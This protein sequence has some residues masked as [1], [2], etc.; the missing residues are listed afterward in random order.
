MAARPGSARQTPIGRNDRQ[1]NPTSRK[2]SYLTHPSRGRAAERRTASASGLRGNSPSR[3]HSTKPGPVISTR[4]RLGTG[5]DAPRSRRAGRGK[6][7][8]HPTSCRASGSSTR[9]PGSGGARALR[10]PSSQTQLAR[11]R[12]PAWRCLL[13]KPPSSAAGPR[14]SSRNSTGREMRELSTRLAWRPAPSRY[15]P[16]PPSPPPSPPLAPS[17]C[18]PPFP[19]R[20]FAAG[21]VG[22]VAGRVG[23][24]DGRP[25]TSKPT[26]VPAARMRAAR[27]ALSPPCCCCRATSPRSCR[28]A[29]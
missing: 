16:S 18:P 17:S 19:L 8:V 4:W 1:M 21:A 6:S 7:S 11:S 25:L 29:R 28:N 22:G 23:P 2:W 9:P 15:P 12:L 5:A 10:P 24:G 3:S 13:R 26:R 14:S 27:A 20:C